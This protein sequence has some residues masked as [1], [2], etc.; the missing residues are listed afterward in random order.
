MTTTLTWTTLHTPPLAEMARISRET[1]QRRDGWN[2]LHGFTTYTRADGE[3]ATLVPDAHFAIAPTT[4]NMLG[5]RLLAGMLRGEMQKRGPE[6]GPIVACTLEVEL[7]AMAPE[8]LAALSPEQRQRAGRGFFEGL[9][10]AVEHVVV[11]AADVAGRVW[12]AYRTRN[13]DPDQFRGPGETGGDPGPHGAIL[14]DLMATVPSW[15]CAAAHPFWQK[16]Q[17]RG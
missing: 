5:V 17:G 14:R 7:Y 1:L 10:G 16:D 9:P 12:F 4:A 3:P 13:D 11:T 8:A 15:Y 6:A 2:L